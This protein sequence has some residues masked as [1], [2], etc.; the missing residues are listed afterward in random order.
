MVEPGRLAALLDDGKRG[1]KALAHLRAHNNDQRFVM[2]NTMYV[3]I[4]PVIECSLF[5]A[6]ALQEMLLQSWGDRIR[7]FPA[8]PPEWKEAVF[9][10][11]RTEGAFLV[12]AERQDGQTR[13]VRIKSLAGAICRVRPGFSGAFASSLPSLKI[14][15][16]EPGVYELDLVRGEE[17]TLFQKRG[18]TAP[19]NR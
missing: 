12:S 1:E 15:E 10:D 8:M 19:D 7:I 4:Y 18:V 6:R 11:F 17:V 2:P 16:V 3:E 14:Q 9:N 13:W 5:A